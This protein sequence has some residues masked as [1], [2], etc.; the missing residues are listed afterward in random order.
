MIFMKVCFSPNPKEC[1]KTNIRSLNHELYLQK[2]LKI[3]HLHLMIKGLMKKNNE[4]NP[5]K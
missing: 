1:D 2:V 5:W 3:K 4:S